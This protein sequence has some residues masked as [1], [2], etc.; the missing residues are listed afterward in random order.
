MNAEPFQNSLAPARFAVS[1]WW[2]RYALVVIAGLAAQ[3]LEPRSALAVPSF[4]RKYNTSCQTC[5]TAFPVLNPFGEAFRR[6][7]FRFP[8]VKGSEDSDAAKEET[9]PLG[10]EEYEKT[11]PNS[12]WPDRISQNV[13]LS[14][15]VGGGVNY[16]M[17]NSDLHSTTGNTFTWNGVAGPVSLFAAGSFSDR[18][19]YYIKVVAATG[20]TNIGAAYLAWNDLLGPRHLVNL[21]FGRLT[22]PQLNSYG[23]SGS[24]LADRAMPNVSIAGLFNPNNSFVLGGPS[25]GAEINGIVLHRISYSMGW[26]ASTAQSGLTVPTSED[27]YFHLGAKFGGMSLDGEGPHGMETVNAKKPW[28]ETSVTLDT[29]GYHGVT[30]VDNLINAPNPTPQR[31]A[32]D[33][34]GYSARL[35]LESLIFTGMVQYQAHRRPYPGSAPTPANPPVQPNALPGA[36]DNHRG[37]GYIGS[38]ELAYVLFPWLIP[39]VRA[40]YTQVGSH[41]GTGSLLRILPGATVLLRPNIRIYVVGDIEHAYKLPPAAP[42]NPS[43]WTLAGGNA[44]PATANSSKTEV[45]QISL[46]ASW[47]L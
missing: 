16:V 21:W 6:N 20:G 32:V 11:F 8:S 34:V 12:V 31:S 29:F 33:A 22:A 10:Q 46:V 45:E 43:W 44:L 14:L 25:D 41:W 36:P 37:H 3:I 15:L 42:P 24:Y 27:G 23:S 35:N 38:G 30:V 9:L 28:A 19:T 5:H 39:A 18:L 40:E 4:A 26:L 2:L 7:G 1:C 17:P 47:A 13:P